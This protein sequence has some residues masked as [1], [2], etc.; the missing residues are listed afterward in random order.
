MRS[1]IITAVAALAAAGCTMNTA[2][3]P[4]VVTDGTTTAVVTPAEPT[5]VVSPDA[6]APLPILG[7]WN[8]NS[9][10]FTVTPGTYR[11]GGGAATRI[12]SIERE[13]ADYRLVLQDG[14]KIRLSGIA[15]GKLTWTNEEAESNK[16]ETMA[17]SMQ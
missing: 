2:D 7:T 5:V 14:K 1:M 11:T 8:C 17:C 16:A 4:V 10:T 13:G 6:T 3:D 9:T 15:D 12:E